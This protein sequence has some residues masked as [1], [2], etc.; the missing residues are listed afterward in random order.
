MVKRRSIVG[1]VGAVALAATAVTSVAQASETKAAEACSLSA[2][3]VTA[4]GAHTATGVTAGTPPTAGK[5][6]TVPNVFQ[7]G[8][9]RLST[10]FRSEPS[11]AG[12]DSYGLVVQGDS[13]YWRFYNFNLGMDEHT[14]IGSGW[15]KFTALEV[16]QLAHLEQGKPEHSIAYGLR[17]DGTLF[18]WT[19]SGNTWR[20]TGSYAGFSAVK[21]MALIAKTPTYDTFLMN[22]RGGALYTVRIPIT[23]PMKPI[24]KPVRTSGWQSFETLVANKCG[25]YGTLLLGI[26]K[27]SKSGYLYAVGHAN[28]TSTV[29]NNL[30]KVDGTFA[31]AVNFRWGPVDYY[32]PLNGD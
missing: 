17:N 29:I 24:V 5:P 25:N 9:V 30:G 16:A 21:S 32:D 26:D 31:D 10:T 4:A 15:S 3:S 1:V 19:T 12:Q 27:D 22:T 2:G 11:V 8:T 14:R 6:Y 7:A 18:R 28:G 20:S 13:L 23:S